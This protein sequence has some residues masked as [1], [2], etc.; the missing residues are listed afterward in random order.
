MNKQNKFL[1]LILF[2]FPF[3]KLLMHPQIRILNPFYLGVLLLAAISISQIVLTKKKFGFNTVDFLLLLFC[4]SF[5]ASTFI[6]ED[7]IRSGYLAY[8]S[9]FIPIAIYFAIKMMAG[10]S[11]QVLNKTINSLLLGTLLFIILSLI[12]SSATG[13]GMGG[14]LSRTAVG[15]AGLGSFVFFWLCFTDF[16]KNIWGKIAIVLSLALIFTTFSRVYFLSILLSPLLIYLIRRG[17]IMTF[18]VLLFP[19]LLIISILIPLNK[20]LFRHN[21]VPSSNVASIKRVFQPDMYKKSFTERALQFSKGLQ[22]F[23]KHPILGTGLKESKLGLGRQTSKSRISTHN[24]HIEWLEYSGIIGYFFISSAFLV[25]FWRQKKII[26]EDN[27]SAIF[28][29][30]IIVTF[31]NSATN[32]IMHGIRPELIFIFMGF[33]EARRK[34]IQPA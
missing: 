1:C 33:L 12:Y 17:H 20:D 31:L 28:V 22:E 11:E 5:L 25:F 24:F 26:A 34:V 2:L 9:V 21:Y 15:A 4:L 13:R 7:I 10:E 27:Q 30:L 29:A 18:F 14:F 32:G 6:A 19:V 8:R 23:Q 3:Y 16:H